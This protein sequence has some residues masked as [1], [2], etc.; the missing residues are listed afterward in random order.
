MTRSRI[1][2]SLAVMTITLASV[3]ALLI[4]RPDLSLVEVGALATVLSLAMERLIKLAQ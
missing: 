1:V 2:L 3:G 4:W